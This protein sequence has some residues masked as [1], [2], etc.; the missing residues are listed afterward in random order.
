MEVVESIGVNIFTANDEHYVGIV[1][2]HSK[3]LAI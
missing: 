1:D 3:I 2:Y